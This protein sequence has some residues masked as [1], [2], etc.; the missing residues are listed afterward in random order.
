MRLRKSFSQSLKK[1]VRKVKVALNNK[2]KTKN[3]VGTINLSEKRAGRD[4]NDSTW[5]D[6]GANL[7]DNRIEHW[8]QTEEERI[9]GELRSVGKTEPIS[10]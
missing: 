8:W 7:Q 3:E 2:K 6:L 10:L 9:M 1:S 5:L 4:I